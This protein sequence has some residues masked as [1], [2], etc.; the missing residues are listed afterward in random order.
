M[1]VIVIVY[2]VLREYGV[3]YLEGIDAAGIFPPD[4]DYHFL[5]LRPVGDIAI[6][7]VVV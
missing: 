1:P 4:P 2:P 7:N 6:G 3:E 5:L